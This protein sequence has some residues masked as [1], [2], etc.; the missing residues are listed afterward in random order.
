MNRR[1]VS[2]VALVSLV[3]LVT[4]SRA[5]STPAQACAGGKLDAAG[6][7]AA[8]MLGCHANGARHGGAVDSACVTKAQTKLTSRFASL[9]ARG[10]C[11]TVGDAGDIAAILD[12]SVDALATALRP[13]TT[14]N[15][16][17][18]TKLKAAGKKAKTKVG[19]HA[20]ATRKG[21][22]VDPQCLAKAE[23]RFASGF[24]S[25]EAHGPCL[26]TDDAAGIESRVDDLMS[27]L[28]AALPSSTT[29]T[30][31]PVPVCGNGVVEGSEQCDTNPEPICVASGRS[32]CFP[33]PGDV[34]PQCECCTTPGETAQ[35]DPSGGNACCDGSLPQPAGPGAYTCQGASTTTISSSTTTTSLACVGDGERCDGSPPCCGADVC[36]GSVCGSA[37]ASICSSCVP[38]FDAV[39]GCFTA[40]CT[41]D[42]DCCTS[43]HKCFTGCGPGFCA[44]ATGCE[45]AG[46]PCC[47]DTG[48]VCCNGGGLCESGGCP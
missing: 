6:K 33:P 46:F 16:C 37:A 41:K 27:Q 4:A 18:A 1:S 11:A 20:K 45:P 35:V 48:A 8:A 7:T 22:A 44:P 28:V 47:G 36:A 12:S 9:E 19:C 43:G 26:T 24:S 32:G 10:G 23:A 40:G 31:V 15:R 21:V 5:A 30:T 3:C 39:G 14:A 34:L 38:D 13:T 17:A 29:T 42:A 2:G 25:A